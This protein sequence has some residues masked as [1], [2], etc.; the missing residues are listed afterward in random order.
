MISLLAAAH[1]YVLGSKLLFLLPADPKSCGLTSVRYGPSDGK[2][3]TGSNLAAP[4][5]HFKV[6]VMPGHL[7]PAWSDP[8]GKQIAGPVDVTYSAEHSDKPQV[9]TGVAAEKIE[10]ATGAKLHAKAD[11]V[12]SSVRVEVTNKGDKP[13][14]LGDSVAARSRPRDACLGPGP[15]AVLAPGETLVDQR[16]G[17]LSKSMQVFVAEF[18]DEKT[19]KWVEVQRSK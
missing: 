12:G 10:P 1:L 14:L 17:L 19:C 6:S 8:E 11:K 15:A 9:V 13:V 5:C 2:W 3:E 7:L 18:S 16:P 4:D